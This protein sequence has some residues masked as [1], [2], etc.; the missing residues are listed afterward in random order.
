M[1]FRKIED[2]NNLGNSYNFEKQ[3]QRP[4]VLRC[5]LEIGETNAMKYFPEIQYYVPHITSKSIIV[6]SGFKQRI[7]MLHKSVLWTQLRASFPIVFILVRIAT[8]TETWILFLVTT[9]SETW[10]LFLVNRK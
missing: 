6:I 8:F 3:Q 9:F 7:D 10:I 5:T 1:K 4:T 2:P